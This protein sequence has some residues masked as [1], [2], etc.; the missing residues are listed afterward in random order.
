[1][2]LQ[3]LRQA[4]LVKGVV[5]LNGGAQALAEALLSFFVSKG[6][7]ECFTATLY[8]CYSLIRP[9]VALEQAW[10]ARLTDSVM[11]F[12]IQYLRHANQRISALEAKLAP[13]EGEAEAAAAAAAA[14]ASGGSGMPG[15]GGMGMVRSF[16]IGLPGR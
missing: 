3:A 11:P 13:K 1:M 7:K 8:T 10:R 14:A 2:L 9:D 15:M 6:D 12:M 16:L 5:R 4:H